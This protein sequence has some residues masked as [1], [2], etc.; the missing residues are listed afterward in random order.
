M[1]RQLR[2]SVIALLGLQLALTFSGCSQSGLEKKPWQKGEVEI[3][4]GRFIEVEER[5]ISS[6]DGSPP[7]KGKKFF[8]TVELRLRWN[9]TNVHWKGNSGSLNLR[10]LEG[11]LF[12]ITFDRVSKGIEECEFRYYAQEGEELKEIPSPQFPKAIAG[13]NLDFGQRYLADWI[14]SETQFKSRG[15]W[16]QGIFTSAK[17]LRLMS[18]II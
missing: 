9:G 1:I 18:G 5:S 17:V 6:D 2:D 16:I 13:Q 14:D 7:Q 4:P 11:R 8:E 12:L 15:T 10:A 3:A